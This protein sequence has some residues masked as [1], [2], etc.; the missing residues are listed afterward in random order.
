VSKFAS[1]KYIFKFYSGI[2]TVY[3]NPVEKAQ[4]NKNAGGGLSRI[5]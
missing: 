2:I 5:V 1:G 3:R 4:I